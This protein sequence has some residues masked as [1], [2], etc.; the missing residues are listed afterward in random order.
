MAIR[1][2]YRVVRCPHCNKYLGR[3]AKVEYR[4][5]SPF[6]VCPYCEK[7]YVDSDYHEIAIEDYRPKSSIGDMAKLLLVCIVC[8]IA[9]SGWSLALFGWLC[10]AVLIVA[11]A[12]L[13]EIIKQVSGIAQRKYEKQLEESKAR[14][15][16]PAYA[17]KLRAAGFNIPPEYDPFYTSR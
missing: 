16:N 4:I 11:I 13:V 15:R 8:A 10:L 3:R 7:E 6:L 14:M 5:G 1:V 17:L 9:V 2:R 12:T